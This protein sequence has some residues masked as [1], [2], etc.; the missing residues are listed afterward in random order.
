MTI[1]PRDIA[2]TGGI[3]AVIAIIIIIIFILVS[4][5]KQDA[6]QDAKTQELLDR[7]KNQ[8]LN[9]QGEPIT[10]KTDDKDEFEETEKTY[11]GRLINLVPGE[12]FDLQT[13]AEEARIWLEQDTEIRIN[14]SIVD[15]SDLSLGDMLEV[16]TVQ[17]KDT[18]IYAIRIN[19]ARSTSPTIPTNVSEPTIQP[20]AINSRPVSPY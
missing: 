15:E 9:A 2:I 19:I 8:G 11:S 6:D 16:D 17:R 1:T 3:T 12:Y 7:I 4:G 5:Q 13:N 18:K 20:P 14:N 10:D